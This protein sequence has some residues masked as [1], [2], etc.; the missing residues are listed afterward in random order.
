MFVTYLRDPA[1]IVTQK[2]VTHDPEKAAQAFEHLVNLELDGNKLCAV[3]NK[4]GTTIAVHDFSKPA[5]PA[6]G[7]DPARY[8]RGKIDQLDLEKK[9]PVF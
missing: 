2:N 4:S 6:D 5:P 3:L 8:W 1:F 7:S 9:S